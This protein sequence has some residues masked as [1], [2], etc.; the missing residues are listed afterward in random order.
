MNILM[1]HP[2]PGLTAQSDSLGPATSTEA[3][4]NFSTIIRRRWRIIAA[5]CILG[6]AVSA[7]VLA[8][9]PKK[10]TATASVFVDFS[11]PAGLITQ[12]APT[13]LGLVDPG[14]VESQ[15]DILESERVA[16]GAIKRLDLRP[17]MPCCIRIL[18]ALDFTGLHARS[19]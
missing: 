15:I 19:A 18:S 10:Y 14:A 11:H 17:P 12:M 3:L 5:T 9:L 1:Q 6:F 2:Q 13:T 4:K 8:I 7:L 16:L